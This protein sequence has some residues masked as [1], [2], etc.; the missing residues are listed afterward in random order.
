MISEGA[1]AAGKV[2]ALST[3]VRD[4]GMGLEYR[5]PFVAVG[6]EPSVVNRRIASGNEV[7]SVSSNGA[8]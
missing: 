4:R 7:L 1:P 8:S 3:V 2:A 5:V 6:S